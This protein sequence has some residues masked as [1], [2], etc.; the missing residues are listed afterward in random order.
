MANT[1]WELLTLP[2]KILARQRQKEEIRNPYDNRMA[3]IIDFC[4]PGLTD[5]FSTTEGSFRG[6]KIYEGTPP[7]ALRVMVNGWLGNLISQSDVWQRYLFPDKKLRGNDRINQWI[8]DLDDYM[9]SVYR[10][11]TEFYEKMPPYALSAFSVGSPVVIIYEDKKTR[12]IKFECPHPKENF[13]GP[14]GSYHRKY[15]I[16][17][18]DAVNQFLDGKYPAT[19]EE[20]G[21]SKLTKE[22]LN[23]YRNGEHFK[24]YKFVR[25]IYRKDDPILA[26]EPAKYKTHEWMEF[27]VQD[28]VSETEKGYKEPILV[29]GYDTK[30]HIRW[31][32]EINDDEFYSRTPGWNAMMDIYSGQEVA[33]QQLEAGQRSL[34]PAQWVRADKKLHFSM[35]PGAKNWFNKNEDP[36]KLSRQVQENVRYDIGKDVSDTKK[37]AIERWFHVP[38]FQ[39]LSQLAATKQGWPTAT[40]V[41]RMDAEKASQLSS[42]IGYFTCVLKEIN[43]RIFDIKRRAG[44]VPEPPPIVYEYMAWRNLMFGEKKL[45]LDLELLGPLAQVQRRNATIQRIETGLVIK[46]AFVEQNPDLVYKTR[47]SVALERALEEVGWPQDCIVP[48]KE[49]Q[50]AIADIKRQEQEAVLAERMSKAADAVPKLSKSVEAG[51]VLGD[52]MGREENA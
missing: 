34:D 39:L 49:Y 23:S 25:G 47:D 51:S 43:D 17:A 7:W 40:H 31:D 38:L 9:D 33:K 35:K 27:Y 5:W 4:Q 41:I 36:E 19:E 50:N 3:D 10:S 52:V 46:K 37:Q 26:K 22:L 1:S 6:E 42:Q 16:T 11:E 13:H 29:Q 30:P 20:V 14:L 45:R 44:M 24:R 21:N 2:A 12:K 8:Q 48:E 18:M 15:P 32:Y 28:G